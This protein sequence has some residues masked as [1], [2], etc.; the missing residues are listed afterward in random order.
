ILPSYCKSWYLAEKGGFGDRA[1]VTGGDS[2][3]GR[4]VCI[5]F[6]REGATVAFIYIK[7]EEKDA[8]ETLRMLLEFIALDAESP[9]AI[10]TALGYDEKQEG[11]VKTYKRIDILVNNAAESH[12]TSV[13]EEITEDKLESF[14]HAL[15]RMRGGSSIINT[16]SVDAYLGNP[17]A[18]DYA[19]STG[20]I[21]AFTRSL[22]VQLVKKGIRVNGVAPGPVWTPLIPAIMKEDMVAKFESE[23]P[24]GRAA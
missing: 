10:P 2:G 11:V 3:I 7:G 5:C 20:A 6:A 21:V 1:L 15:K 9:I 4:A 8:S 14:W 17:K 12:L 13:V 19:S 18:M 22:A 23:T 24:M 16:T